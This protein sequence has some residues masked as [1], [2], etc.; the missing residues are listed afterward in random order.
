MYRVE[1]FGNGLYGVWNVYAR[2][3]MRGDSRQTTSSGWFMSYLE[4]WYYARSLA[5]AEEGE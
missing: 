4:A 3:Y 1:S 2:M 5:T